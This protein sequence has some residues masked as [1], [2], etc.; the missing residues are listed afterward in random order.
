M[1]GRTTMIDP[2]DRSLWARLWKP[3]KNLRKT[4]KKPEDFVR[5]APE[6]NQKI[7]EEGVGLRGLSSS[8]GWGRVMVFAS[9]LLGKQRFF[10]KTCCFEGLFKREFEKKIRVSL[11][12]GTQI[13][14]VDFIWLYASLFLNQN[15]IWGDEGRVS[16]PREQ[17]NAR[18][19]FMRFKAIAQEDCRKTGRLNAIEYDN[20]RENEDEKWSVWS[21]S[22]MNPLKTDT[23]WLR[24]SFISRNHIPYQ[25]NKTNTPKPKTL[26][27]KPP[28]S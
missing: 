18:V 27:P 20:I 19:C 14:F 10:W 13:S 9:G 15:Y 26:N 28:N 21:L 5:A 1:G 22:C 3:Q 16:W 12:F 24:C 11:A 17:K 6:K 4:E 8:W 23:Y 2:V 25:E 7:R